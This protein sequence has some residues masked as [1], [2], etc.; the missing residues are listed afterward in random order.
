MT[1]AVYVAID[2]WAFIVIINIGYYCLYY[3]WLILFYNLYSKFV[4]AIIIRRG[5][6]RHLV[7]RPCFRTKVNSART[8]FETLAISIIRS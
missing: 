8:P 2:D 6:T 7:G 3:Y 5:Y 4:A 1:F